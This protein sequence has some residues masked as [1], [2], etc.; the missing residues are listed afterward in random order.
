MIKSKKWEKQPSWTKE[1]EFDEKLY[2]GDVFGMTALGDYI[3]ILHTEG[4]LIQ[5]LRP[6][7][8]NEGWSPV[9]LGVNESRIIGHIPNLLTFCPFTKSDIITLSN[10][11]FDF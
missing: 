1:F 8:P 9:N 10:N 11:K 6:A 5:R 2:G 7:K 3:Y 4:N